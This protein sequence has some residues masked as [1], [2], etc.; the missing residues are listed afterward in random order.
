MSQ[1]PQTNLDKG[2]LGCVLLV[3]LGPNGDD[4]TSMTGP[5]VGNDTRT[6]RA[7]HRVGEGGVDEVRAVRGG[8]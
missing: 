6:R 3:K 8:R 7:G 1:G 5:C 4:E 2:D